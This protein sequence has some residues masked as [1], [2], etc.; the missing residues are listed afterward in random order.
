MDVLADTT[1]SVEVG[2]N[3][4]LRRSPIDYFA[5]FDLCLLIWRHVRCDEASLLGKN[6]KLRRTARGRRRAVVDVTI[7]CSES[8][9][10]WAP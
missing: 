9:G 3:A 7:S 6:K 8:S 1:R 5:H 2:A 10:T 4:K